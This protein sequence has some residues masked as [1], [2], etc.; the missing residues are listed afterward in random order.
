M[1]TITLFSRLRHSLN[2]SLFDTTRGIK[3]PMTS[4]PTRRSIQPM[5]TNNTQSSVLGARLPSV[6]LVLLTLQAS[7]REAW[8]QVITFPMSQSSSQTFKLLG[9]ISTC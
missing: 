1:T 2:Y 6:L 5:E 3:F 4:D 9:N 8:V 7:N